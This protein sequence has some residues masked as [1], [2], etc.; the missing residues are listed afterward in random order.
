MGGESPLVAV[1]SSA[2]AEELPDARSLGS[3]ETFLMYREKQ[4]VIKN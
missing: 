2:T 3:K 4:F 1:R